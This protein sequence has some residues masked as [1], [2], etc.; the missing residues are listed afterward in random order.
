MTLHLKDL[1]AKAESKGIKAKDHPA[2]FLKPWQEESVLFNDED[3]NNKPSLEI[4]KIKTESTS[5]NRSKSSQKEQKN[6]KQTGDKL[7]TNRRQSGDK[8]G[9]KAETKW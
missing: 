5:E 4:T 8:T 2:P 7:E 6:W 3:V 9:D 1:I